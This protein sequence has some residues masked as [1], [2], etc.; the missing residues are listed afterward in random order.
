MPTPKT[1]EDALYAILAAATGV[2]SLVGNVSPA[3]RIYPDRAPDLHASPYIVYQLITGARDQTQES[4]ESMSTQRF[5]LDCISSV[6]STQAKI[7]AAEVKN[8]LHGYKGTIAGVKV[9]YINAF[10]GPG[11]F[12]DTTKVYRRIVEIVV[13][14]VE[15]Q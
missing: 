5:Q 15:P 7:L 12:S 4:A 1:F 8:A 2:T 14:F 13:M 10:D 3:P 11:G 9:D 6:S